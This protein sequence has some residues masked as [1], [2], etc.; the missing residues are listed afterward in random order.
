MGALEDSSPV[1]D[2]VADGVG[3]A[4]RALLQRLIR[5]FGLLAGDTTPCGKPLAVSHAH[6]LMVLLEQA[7]LGRTPGQRELGAALG[8]DK[9]NVARLCRRMEKAG[10]LRQAH[11]SEDGR[12]RVLSLTPQGTRV[13]AAVERSSRARFADLAAA[14]PAAHRPAVLSAL[15]LLNRAIAASAA[16]ADPTSARRGPRPRRARRAGGTTS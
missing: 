12:A 13:A 16:S 5:S 15:E 6:A 14:V 10:H 8:I 7:R 4:L 3:R 1:E 11:S 9:S 2:L